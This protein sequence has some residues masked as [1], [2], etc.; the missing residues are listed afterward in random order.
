MPLTEEQLIV[1]VRNK[2]TDSTALLPDAKILEF[3]ADEGDNDYGGVLDLNGVIADAWEY[4]A[5]NYQ[6]KS[7]TIGNVSYSQPTA[8]ATAEFYRSKS[9]TGGA[10]VVIGQMSRADLL[11]PDT[12]ADSEFGEGD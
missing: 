12:T 5:R 1:K 7:A 10:I 4:L 8:F 6:Y 11:V 9:G 3:A 2:T